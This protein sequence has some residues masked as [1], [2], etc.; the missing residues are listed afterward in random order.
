MFAERKPRKKSS[1]INITS[2]VD[3]QFIMLLFFMISSTFVEKP[4][5]DLLLP[6]AKTAELKRTDDIIITID[7]KGTLYCNGTKIDCDNLRNK[8]GE[9]QLQGKSKAQI[10]L[11]ADENVAYKTV[12]FV[13]DTARDMG[14]SNM[15]ALTTNSSDHE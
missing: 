10:V 5:I 2:L 11:E 14:F 15:V 6:Q 8:L 1:I 4:G 3:V 13:M 12:V 7:K 9:L